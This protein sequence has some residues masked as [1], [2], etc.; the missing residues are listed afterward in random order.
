MTFDVPG[1]PIPRR[2]AAVWCIGAGL[3][4]WLVL[5]PMVAATVLSA[6]VT[7]LV[8]LR[9]PLV[10]G[11]LGVLGVAVISTIVTSRVR[12]DEIPADFGFPAA[13]E[14]LHRPMAAAV[15]LVVLAVLTDTRRRA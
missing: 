14:D 10:L 7:A 12:N 6:A 2:R 8:V 4:S 13:F 11:A 9:R 5:G 3:V 1:G 15:L